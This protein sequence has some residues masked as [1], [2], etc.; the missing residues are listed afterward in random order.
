MRTLSDLFYR[1]CTVYFI[2]IVRFNLQTLYGVFNVHCTIYLTFYI[3]RNFVKVQ[4]ELKY[5]L[6]RISVWHKKILLASIFVIYPWIVFYY[7]KSYYKEVK[8]QVFI[9]Q[10]SMKPRKIYFRKD[11]SSRLPIEGK[12]SVFDGRWWWWVHGFCRFIDFKNMTVQYNT[13]ENTLV[14][15]F[16]NI[17]RLN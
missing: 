6:A 12:I 8:Y 11:C 1:H 17:G 4:G 13:L 3:F 16:V 10:L 7:T 14:Y 9:M 5:P 15:I 2:D